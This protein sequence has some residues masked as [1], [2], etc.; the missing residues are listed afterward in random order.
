M[1]MSTAPKGYI[2][3]NG[4]NRSLEERIKNWFFKIG[5]KNRILRIIVLPLL[6][7]CMFV[8]HVIHYCG[9]NGKRFF[10]LTMTFFTF[11]IYS[12][13][14]FP[15]FVTSDQTGDARGSVYDAEEN[16][17][18]L[19]QET[20]VDIEDMEPLDEEALLEDYEDSAMS[21][22]MSISDMY[23]A[24]DILEYLEGRETKNEQQETPGRAVMDF[25]RDDWKLVLINKEHSIP[26]NYTFELETFI[27]DKKCD[28]RIID[29]LYDMFQAAKED[30]INLKVCSPYRDDERQTF[31]FN[32]KMNYYIRRGMSYLEAYQLSSQVV[33][34][35]GASEHQIGLALDIVC[36][37][38]TE[39]DEGFGDTDAGKWLAENSCKYG[40]IL[41]YP[42]GKEYITLVEYEPWHFR[43]VGVDAATIIMEQEIT[44]EEFWEEYL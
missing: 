20:A 11:V 44:L 17:V 43:Y 8:F 41:R 42:K 24:E 3:S 10:M 19:V 1:N 29:D 21:H 35:P 5:K 22:G 31:L 33:M 32:R 40:F 23:D 25:S 9:N 7:F 18:T 38:Y 36:D 15:I 16:D 4:T 14:S 39:L 2:V 34:V 37:T 6:T 27:D 30:G 26:E 13:F 28:S 12:S